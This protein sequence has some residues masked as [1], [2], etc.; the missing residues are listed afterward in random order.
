MEVFINKIY[1]LRNN[2]HDGI[3]TSPQALILQVQ[4]FMLV[5]WLLPADTVVF[6]L[7]HSIDVTN[8]CIEIV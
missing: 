8:S 6:D 2:N 7:S 5:T 1:Y 4:V 3:P